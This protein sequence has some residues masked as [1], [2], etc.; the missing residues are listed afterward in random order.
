MAYIHVY[1]DSPKTLVLLI[2]E[3]IPKPIKLMVPNFDSSFPF[4]AGNLEVIEANI[5]NKII[6]VFM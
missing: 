3:F 2:K 5:Q 4:M 6:N 1:Y